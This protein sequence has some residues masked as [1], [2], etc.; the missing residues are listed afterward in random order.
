M[1]LW[2]MKVGKEPAG[3]TSAFQAQLQKK[4]WLMKYINCQLDFVVMT[5]HPML[6]IIR[7]VV[8]CIAI[9]NFFFVNLYLDMSFELWRFNLKMWIY[10]SEWH[11]RR[12]VMNDCRARSFLQFIIKVKKN[13][14]NNIFAFYGPCLQKKKVI[15]LQKQ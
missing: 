7:H 15:M 10:K 14:S 3:I 6:I 2:R 1:D 8:I 5:L 9:F 13:K 4:I 11:Q 12:S